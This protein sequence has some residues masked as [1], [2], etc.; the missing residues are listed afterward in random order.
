MWPG[1]FATRLM[2]KHV[3]KFGAGGC[4]QWN[5]CCVLSSCSLILKMTLKKELL[6]LKDCGVTS[7][8]TVA[9]LCRLTA[10]IQCSADF[11]DLTI[12]QILSLSH[13]LLWQT[14]RW[15]YCLYQNRSSSHEV[16]LLSSFE[17]LTLFLNDIRL[18]QHFFQSC[19]F[20]LFHSCYLLFFFFQRKWGSVHFNTL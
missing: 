10:A 1:S 5:L 12:K 18:K 9:C 2:I 11:S 15:R 8:R 14:Q 4:V 17:T 6:M 13:S 16:S 20:W 19:H 7:C 3:C